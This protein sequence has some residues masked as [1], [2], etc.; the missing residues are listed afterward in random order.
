MK[1]YLHNPISEY[2]LF[3]KSENDLKVIGILQDGVI[4]TGNKAIE[5][6]KTGNFDDV[7]SEQRAKLMSCLDLS[8]QWDELAKQPVCITLEYKKD[9]TT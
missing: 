1:K 7:V 5:L 6:F 8:P 9:E 3:L 2:S 4:Y